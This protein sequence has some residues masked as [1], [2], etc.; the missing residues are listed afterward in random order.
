MLPSAVL[1][2]TVL[3]DGTLAVTTADCMV[4]LFR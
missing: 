3:P 2:L 1:T 4:R